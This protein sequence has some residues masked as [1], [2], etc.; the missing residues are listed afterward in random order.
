MYRRRLHKFTTCVLS[1][2]LVLYD[3]KICLKYDLSSL[4]QIAAF[5]VFAHPKYSHIMLLTW[6]LSLT[7]CATFSNHTPKLDGI[8]IF[9]N[10]L[11]HLFLD[12][13]LYFKNIW[14]FS[15]DKFRMNLYDYNCFLCKYVFFAAEYF[16][17]IFSYIVSVLFICV[18]NYFVFQWFIILLNLEYVIIMNYDSFD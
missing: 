8:G 10:I 15:V 2:C 6:Y 5:R 1:I 13:L 3:N 12:T 16:L 17:R 9:C 7:Q 4:S 18:H 14:L 11:W